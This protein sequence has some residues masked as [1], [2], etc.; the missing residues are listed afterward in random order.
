V[1]H[2]GRSTIPVDKVLSLYYKWFEKPKPKYQP[3]QTFDFSD[4]DL[5]C[6]KDFAC[7]DLSIADMRYA[8]YL[9]RMGLSDAE[10]MQRLLA[11]SPDIE[12]RHKVE[13][14]LPRTIEKAKQYVLG[15]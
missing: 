12:K 6:W 4:K 1:V 7:E 15:G 2:T 5:K 8:C 9:V 11:E 3:K 10:I 13:D 14:Y